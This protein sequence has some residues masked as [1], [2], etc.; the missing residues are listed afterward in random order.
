LCAGLA[1]TPLFQHIGVF[2]KEMALKSTV[3]TVVYG[4]GRVAIPI[5]L[6]VLST[7]ALVGNSFN[8][9]LYFRF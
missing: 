1:F 3:A 7:A 4:A 8:P 9:F 2:G 6:L 5:V